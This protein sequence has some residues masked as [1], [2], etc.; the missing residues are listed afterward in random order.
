MKIQYNGSSKILKRL[1]E[2]VNRSQNVAL[3]QDNTDKNT[4]YWTGLDGVEIT[5]NI[6]SVAVEVD[7]ELSETSTNPVENQAITKELAQKADK[8]AIP[9]VGDG[10]LSVQRNGKSVGTFSAN[11]AKDT[12][13][14]ISVPE[15]VSEL[16]NDAGYG[17]YTKPAAGIPKSDL[18]SGVQASLGKADTALQKH[19]DISGKLDKTGDASTTTVAFSAASARENV[20]TG[21]KLSVIVGKIAKWFADLKTVAFTGSYNDLANK[22]TI[23]D[24]SGKQ[25][26]L[27]AGTNITISGNTISAKDTTYGNAS[28]SVAGLMSAADKTKLDGIATGANKTVADTALSSTSTNPVQNKVVKAALDGKAA[29]SHTHSYLPLSGGTITGNIKWEG[30][31][32]LPRFS[33]E[34]GFLLGIESFANGGVTKWQ[35]AGSVN[36]GTA[37]KL[38]TARTINGVS[39]DGT[40]NI[41]T[42]YAYNLQLGTTYSSSSYTMFAR[43]SDEN[44]YYNVGATIL[45]TDAGMYGGERPGAW[46]IQLTNRSSFP[47]MH[48]RTL[49]PH[50]QGTV[51]FGYYHDTTNGYFYFGVYTASYR[52][53][54]N[55]TVLRNTSVE[56]KDYGDI[57]TAP[58]GWTAVTPVEFETKSDSGWIATTRNT[59]FT[60]TS[61][62]KCRKYGQLIE[63]RGEVTFS[64]TCG[65]PTVCTLPAGYRP[66]TV[67][68]AC[69]ITPNGKQYM[70][71]ADTSGVI[72]FGSDS[73]STFVKGTTYRVDLTYLLG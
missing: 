42:A 28:A 6:P 29:S 19:Q 30:D 16:E 64:D 45:F 44:S 24:V 22:P 21:E 55:I 40:A 60:E 66:A 18:A 67:V 31:Y 4:L 43:T 15:K 69:G 53:S 59:T 11:A 34:P 1:V 7:T 65:S 2:L 13:V 57:T 52:A 71:K 36:V 54:G 8:S 51:Q 63:V 49:I 3:R 41:N 23:P 48:V 38:K 73:G 72:S 47:S 61:A 20:K 17:T 70:I 32:A 56:I 26:K 58:S 35:H 46:I 14:S 39:F 10:V 27:T 9:T 33:G 37:T 50:N 68:Q 5:V 25:D 62:V 12:A